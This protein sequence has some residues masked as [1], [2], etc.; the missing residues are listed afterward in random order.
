MVTKT[1]N[2]QESSEGGGEVEYME[3]YTVRYD[4]MIKNRT[5]FLSKVTESTK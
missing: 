2:Y 5:L 3:K 4:V 1:D